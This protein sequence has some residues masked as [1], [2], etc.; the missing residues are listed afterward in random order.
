MKKIIT[1]M[2]IVPFLVMPIMAQAQTSNIDKDVQDFSRANF[3]EIFPDVNGI[4]KYPQDNVNKVRP[5]NHNVDAPKRSSY[6]ARRYETI[7]NY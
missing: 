6:N 1:I 5:Y 2:L 3:T 4:F 7:S